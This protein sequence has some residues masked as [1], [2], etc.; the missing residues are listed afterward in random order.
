MSSLWCAPRP[1]EPVTTASIAPAAKVAL[2]AKSET[3]KK[4]KK[5]VRRQDW[6]NNFA[7]AHPWQWQN[8]QTRVW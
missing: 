2:A 8:S 1:Y 5:V 6:R 7:Q 4:T 3:K